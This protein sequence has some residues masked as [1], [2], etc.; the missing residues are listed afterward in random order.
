VFRSPTVSHFAPTSSSW[1]NLVE[2]WFGELTAKAVRRG[3]FASVVDLEAAIARFL[4]AWNDN[5]NPFVSTA[6]VESI[7]AKLARCR[8]TLEQ[9]KPGC[10]APRTRKKK[11]IKSPVI[12]RTPH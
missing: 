12:S 9:I 5:P 6:T 10:T 4:E 2:R 3:S 11:K 1:L 8:Q 7:Q